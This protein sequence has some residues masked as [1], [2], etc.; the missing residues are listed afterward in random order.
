MTVTVWSPPPPGDGVAV[1]AALV[2]Y[3]RCVVVVC[4]GVVWRGVVCSGVVAVCFGV[5]WYVVVCSG[6]VWRTVVVRVVGFVV[7][8]SENLRQVEVNRDKEEGD[9]LALNCGNLR[10]FWSEADII[11]CNVSCVVQKG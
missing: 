2:G 11:D 1:G 5:V 6:V 9:D 3:V 4:F 10:A 8:S 7:G